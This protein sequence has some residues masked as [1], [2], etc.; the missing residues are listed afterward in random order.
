MI[1]EIDMANHYLKKSKGFTLVELIVTL[2][3]LSI[4][5][6]AAFSF[7]IFGNK[8]YNRGINQYSVQSNIRLASDYITKEI[9]YA[10]Q[11]EVLPFDSSIEDIINNP[12]ANM[13]AY[14][15]Y[16][17]YHDEKIKR[18]SRYM[19][20]SYYIGSGGN[21]NFSS[22]SGEILNVHIDGI[23]NGQAYDI[24]SEISPLNLDISSSTINV[25]SGDVIRYVTADNYLA[26]LALPIVTPGDNTDPE[27]FVVNFSKGIISLTIISPDS[28][29]PT[30]TIQDSFHLEFSVPSP[31][32][33]SGD[34]V[35]V[36]VL[37]DDNVEYEY[38]IEYS[39]LWNIYF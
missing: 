27:S 17:V 5:L 20:D 4:V 34:K 1:G 11:I 8:T 18:V 6:A 38:S 36:L 24:D 2:V 7:F 14:E 32:A 3:I 35:V 26:K 19:S 9:R 30:V 15:N 10:T 22:S 28:N 21:L 23:D 37:M 16:I 39:T 29:D 31:G 25:A 13:D 12:L 33:V